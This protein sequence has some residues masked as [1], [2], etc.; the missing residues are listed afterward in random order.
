MIISAPSSFVTR[1]HGLTGAVSNSLLRRATPPPL[2]AMEPENV[3][4][5]VASWGIEYIVLTM[6]DR[7]DLEDSG[8][9][10]VAET[11]RLLKHKTEG[12]LLVET[13]VG[14]FQGNHIF[15]KPGLHLG[16]LVFRGI[17]VNATLR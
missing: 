5:A 1:S 14:D 16:S 10:H 15:T 6:V 9:A 7:D 13:L 8:A 4:H 3:S 12:K 11:V 2:D 17:T